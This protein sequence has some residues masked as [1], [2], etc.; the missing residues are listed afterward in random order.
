[1]MIVRQDLAGKGPGFVLGNADC[2]ILVVSESDADAA[3]AI[4]KKDLAR[5]N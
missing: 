5:P 1:M 4:V 2:E 3:L